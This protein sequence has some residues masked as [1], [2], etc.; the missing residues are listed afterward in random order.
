MNSSR[1]AAG[2]IRPYWTV[3]DLHDRQAVQRHL[4]GRDDGGTASIPSRLAVGALDEVLGERLDLPD[5]DRRRR[6]AP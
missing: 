1:A 4:L 2:S 6:P 5:V 3:R